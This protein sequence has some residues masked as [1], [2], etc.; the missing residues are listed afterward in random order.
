MTTRVTV[1][2][3]NWPARVTLADSS[4]ELVPPQTKRI[5]TVTGDTAVTV[6]EIPPSEDKAEEPP[7]SEAD[8]A[9]IIPLKKRGDEPVTADPAE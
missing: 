9:P 1:E 4:G 6:R 8:K 7:L 5:F 3:N 2:T